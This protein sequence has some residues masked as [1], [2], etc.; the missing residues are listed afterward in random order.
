[1]TSNM[2]KNTIQWKKNVWQIVEMKTTDT[3]Y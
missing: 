3:D 1:M 2:V